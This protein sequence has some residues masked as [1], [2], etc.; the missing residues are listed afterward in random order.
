[1]RTENHITVIY[2][3]R[4]NEPSGERLRRVIEMN[5]PKNNIAVCR[6]IEELSQSL[7][8]P[9]LESPI[10]AL[11]AAD[12]AEL[13]LFSPMADLLQDRR[14]ILILPDNDSQTLS[15]GHTFRP[16]FIAFKGGD[17]GDVSVV[18]GKMLNNCMDMLK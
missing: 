11:L 5:V 1:M 14:L 8:H 7:R 10:V 6:S 15:Q 16:R 17:Y 13:S 18:L 9:A 2:Y 12:R 4:E 3:S